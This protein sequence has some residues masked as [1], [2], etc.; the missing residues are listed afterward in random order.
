VHIDHFIDIPED[1]TA[2][3]AEV[4]RRIGRAIQQEYSPLRVGLVV[5]GFGVPHA[6]FILVP[7]QDEHDITSGRFAVVEDGVVRFRHG[8]IPGLGREELDQH[9]A[10]LRSRVQLL[11]SPS[12]RRPEHD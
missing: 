2:H 5:H 3:L 4:V 11:D 10:R 12:R 9:A 8:I 1:L 6:H 7:Q